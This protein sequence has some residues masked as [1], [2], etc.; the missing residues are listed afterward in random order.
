MKTKSNYDVLILGAGPAG[1]SAS[2]LLSEQGHRVLVLEREK[3]PRYHIGESL[4]PFTYQPLERLGLIGKM[5]K[6]AFVK[7]YSVQFVSPS[8][9]ASLPF[10]F[11]NRYDRESIA[12]T[13]Q[14][15]RS[16]FDQM[17]L[18]NTREKGTTVLE[19][20]TVKELIWEGG[21]V[22]G[23]RAQAKNGEVTDYRASI[24]LDCTGKEAFT[25]VRNN[26]RVKDPFL[27]KVAVWT[28]YEG[29]K[30]DEG[31]D[32]GATT[33]AYVPEKG[34]FWY[35]PQHNNRISVGVV[36][37]G[38]Y[39]TRG[40]IKSPE[41]IFKREIEQNLWI[42]EHLAAG[43]QVG[44]YFLTSEYSHHSKHCA[45]E[46]LLLVGDAF[47]FL[48]PVFS[49]GVMLA[50]KSGVMAADAVHQAIVEQDF[51]PER[52]S[53]YATMLR[54]GVENMRKLV[55]AFYEPAFSFGKVIKKYPDAAG[56]ITDCLSG[57]V[58]KD[59]SQLWKWIAEFV[60]LPDDLPV[61]QPLTGSPQLAA[62]G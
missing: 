28:Y 32:E 56:L 5:K 37:E 43:K 12:Q 48:D 7:K 11:F 3:F 57:D 30:R 19:E 40:G 33:V 27:N 23:A 16:E 10:Y 45:T 31:V 25:A 44:S 59:F 51:A 26:W 17:L 55:Y 61:G 39:L 50:L 47:A 41:E 52:F 35:I 13:W 24:T 54:Q 53:D 6:S 29:A 34:W 21:R 8:G 46:G 2:A 58:N 9:R 15:L 22:V 14:V 1:S 20:T 18:E 62:K 4:L 49:S 36:A 38:K 60:P 42:K